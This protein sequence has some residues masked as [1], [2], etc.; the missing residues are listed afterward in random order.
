[1]EVLNSKAYYG[2][3]INF[4][5]RAQELTGKDPDSGKD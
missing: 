2:P 3:W 4:I 5:V 1:M